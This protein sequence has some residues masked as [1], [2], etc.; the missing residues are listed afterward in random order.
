MKFH[1]YKN[2]CK[3]N[4]R[5]PV[6]PKKKFVHEISSKKFD[7]RKKF[8]D[9][10]ASQEKKRGMI[11]ESEGDERRIWGEREVA[12]KGGERDT[13]YCVQWQCSGHRL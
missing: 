5:K 1:R 13:Y 12:K 2:C 3:N 9:S 10:Y 7:S 6:T 11:A 4:F 8:P